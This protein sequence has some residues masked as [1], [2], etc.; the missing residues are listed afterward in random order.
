MLNFRVL[1]AL[2]VLSELLAMADVVV[3][4]QSAEVLTGD[5]CDDDEAASL[6]LRQL[7]GDFRLSAEGTRDADAAAPVAKD[8]VWLERSLVADE[9][10]SVGDHLHTDLS[11]SGT[12]ACVDQ[13]GWDVDFASR[14]YSCGFRTMGNAYRSGRC[15]AARQ[16]ISY[17]CGACIGNHIHC[18]LNCK[19]ECCLGRCTTRPACWECQVE[20]C[21]PAFFECAGVYPPRPEA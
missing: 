18:G 10:N 20:K 14:C 12:N 16:H 6:S 5:T 3:P 19:R 11:T 8:D 15:M 2:G 1:L 17:E 4:E 21:Q 9:G 7:R 13:T